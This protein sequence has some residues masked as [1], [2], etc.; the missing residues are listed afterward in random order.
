[1]S[2]ITSNDQLQALCD[3]L[4][5]SEYITVDTEFL[6]DKT[7]YSKLC[8]IQVANEEEYH[9]ID[10]LAPGIDLEPFYDLMRNENIIKVFHA[11]R[12][13]IE[14]F[15]VEKGVVPKPLF[16]S[17]V[18]A[19]VCG[20]GDSIGYE[21]LV[22]SLA[23]ATL[24]KSTRITDWSRRPL[25]QRQIDYALGDVTHLRV[26]YKKLKAQLEK[27]GRSAWLVE[28]MAELSDPETF[29][30]RPENAWKRLKIRSSNRL[31]N[32]VAR[33]LAEWREKEAQS[34]NLP[35]NRVMRDEVLLE[36]SAVRPEHA[37]AL[38]SIRGLSPQF[39]K[40]KSGDRLLEIIKDI[41]ARP[42]D[43]LPAISRRRPPAQNT[44]P[45]MEL[46]KVLLKLICQ[47]ENVAPKLIAS[48]DDLEKLAEND[49]ADIQ[50]L[51]GWRYDLFG[52]AALA[53]KR[54][55]MGFVL[56]DGEVT[57]VDMTA[58]P[59]DDDTAQDAD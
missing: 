47:R 14:I 39:S 53:V 8:L 34:R 33:E 3:R 18:A 22:L 52:K 51:S 31:F 11:S 40:S 10:T 43:E 20:Y 36:V 56:Q 9:A 42:A 58:A 30:I 50:A 4:S 17:Q 19:M 29:I 23:N 49:D 48:V 28:E 6:R 7:Y 57:L 21:K 27:S 32:A 5:T 59:Q 2:V 41:S 45:V 12:Q 54:G 35:R 55:E 44:D 16:D 26:I 37:N 46:L 13:D 38:G 1:M 15:V 24:D 25:S